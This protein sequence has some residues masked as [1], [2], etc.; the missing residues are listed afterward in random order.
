MKPY[1]PET[2]NDHRT[3][4][5]QSASSTLQQNLTEGKR[6]RYPSKRIYMDIHKYS[7]AHRSENIHTKIKQLVKILINGNL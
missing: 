5:M 4:H 6:N 1:S 2:K 7:I 3:R